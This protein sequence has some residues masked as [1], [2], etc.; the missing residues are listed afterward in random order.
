MAKTVVGLFEDRA[1]AQNALDALVDRGFTRDQVSVAASDVPGVQGPETHVVTDERP[2]GA[3]AAVGAVGGAMVGGGAGLLVGLGALVIPG[4]GPLVA[5]GPLVTTLAGMAAG[6]VAGGLLGALVDLGIPKE[7]AEVYVEG[8][9]RGYIL[10]TLRT[11]DE[12]ADT[13]ASVMRANG[14]VD[15]KERAAAWRQ[16]GWAGY[17]ANAKPYTAAEIARERELYSRRRAQAEA[18]TARAAQQAVAERNAGTASV[19]GSRYGEFSAYE[20]EFRRDFETTLANRSYKFDH[21]LPAYRYGYSLATNPR[22]D[23]KD[24]DHVESHVRAYWE[25]RNPGT[26]EEFMRP[27]RYAWDTVRGR[28]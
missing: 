4:L 12:D 26:W 3:G 24:W 10:V 23:G 15:V 22:Y 5:M 1:D 2:S 28:R 9:R 25:E 14:A 8:V 7:E 27:I 21:H 13:A 6:T 20:E 18:A 19:A 17:D 11:S 16:S